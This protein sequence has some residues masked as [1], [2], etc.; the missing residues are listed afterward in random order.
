MGARLSFEKYEGLG[1]DF[2]LLD[3]AADTEVTPEDAT[4]LCDRRFGVGADGVILVLPARVPGCDARIRVI[5]ADGSVPE[6]CGNGVR[7]VALHVA[8][9]R[10]RTA[11]TVRLETDAGERACVLDGDGMVTVDMGIVRVL[12][13][14]AVD[15]DGRSIVLSLA[16]AGNPHAVLFGAFAR[17]DVEHLGPRIATH[18]AF[19]RGTN[20][21][22]ACVLGDGIDLVVWERGVGVTM[23]CGTGACATA[24]VACD[25]GLVARGKPVTVRLPGG[26]LDVTVADDGRTTMRGPARRVYS[27]TT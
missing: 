12:G 10:G 21:E 4:R 9:A 7:C 16:D 6:M 1:N 19:P 25:K 22:F 8:A 20:V 11:G 17:G 15:V 13:Q 2:I 23:A 14:R 18:A 3:A 5:N 26:R 27:G 24:A